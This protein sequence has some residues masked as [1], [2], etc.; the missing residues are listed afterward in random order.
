MSLDHP[1]NELPVVV[2]REPGRTPLVLV[3]HQTLDIGRDGPGLLIDDPQASR[4]H[5]QLEP[6]DDGVVV[7]DLG[8]TNGTFLDGERVTEATRFLP[9]SRLS[10]GATTI[11][12]LP[13]LMEVPPLVDTV[14]TTSIERLASKMADGAVKRPSGLKHD[15]TLTIV[16]TDIESS[17]ELSTSL[18]DSEWFDLLSEHNEL[19]R[20]LVRDHGGTEVKAQGDGF[21]LA[22]DS[23]RR[24]LQTMIE[25]QR[26]ITRAFG[27]HD[28]RLNI[29]IGAHTGEA[30]SDSAGDLYGYH[31]NLAARIAD[32]AVG[33]EILVS[34]L[35]KQIGEARG[36]FRFGE[37][38]RVQLKGLGGRYVV[39]PV[40]WS[41]SSS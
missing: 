15:A 36:E 11:E 37:P 18:G 7:S 21:M 16:F 17:T 25:A 9:G 33:G 6:T 10:V 24:A 40:D 29:R 8:S 38:R 35:L 5:L 2:V 26:D 28:P 32:R 20:R 23:T 30:I 19:L 27:N 41:I 3:L 12:L 1:L 14:S 31:V 39:Y 13:A 4:N 34:E 22:F